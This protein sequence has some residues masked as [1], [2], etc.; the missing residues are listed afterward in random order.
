MN[1]VRRCR[2][3]EC[4]AQIRFESTH[5]GARIPLDAF[6]VA[7]ENDVLQEAVKGGWVYGHGLVRPHQAGERN[8]YLSHF[9]TCTDPNRFSG[10]KK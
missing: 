7:E 10:G 5:A 9:M 4:R 2:V 1:P 6:P 8:C 3:P